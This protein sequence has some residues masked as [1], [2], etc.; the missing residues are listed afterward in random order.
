MALLS[1]YN[2]KPVEITEKLKWDRVFKWKPPEQ[3]SIDFFAKFE[4]I[5]TIEGEKYREISL[6]VGYNSK[7]YGKYTINEAL[8]QIYD[9]EYRKIN[10]EQNYKYS[11]KLFKPA[12]Y[13]SIGVEKS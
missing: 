7:Q 12:K 1:Y 8:R 9:E 13:Y 11:L 6:M 4:N 2:N 5:I 3:N 10:N